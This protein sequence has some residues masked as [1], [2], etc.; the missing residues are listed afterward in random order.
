MLPP[1]R[2]EFAE[3]GMIHVF[4]AL[5]VIAIMVFVY[6]RV[7]GYVDE[8][9]AEREA[10]KKASAK[11]DIPA[12]PV[13][14]TT[15]VAGEHYKVLYALGL[16]ATKAEIS[17]RVAKMSPEERAIAEQKIARII[18]Q[19]PNIPLE[20]MLELTYARWDAIEE[21]VEAQKSAK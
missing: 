5:A 9:L 6:V 2:S 14:A 20:K 15:R 4:A 21:Y 3:H 8:T 10:A 19:P 11:S 16:V 1:T 13:D 17:E 18:K 12:N 7:Q